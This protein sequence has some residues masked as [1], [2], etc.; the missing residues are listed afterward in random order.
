M[1]QIPT[2]YRELYKRNT[3]DA[4]QYLTEHCS[5]CNGTGYIETQENMFRDCE[6]VNEFYRIKK[7]IESGIDVKS[8]LLK[9][10]YIIEHFNEK[11]LN[12]L[13]TIVKEKPYVNIV[14]FPE[15]NKSW[16]SDI[17][18]KYVLRQYSDT[19]CA[20]VSAKQLIDFFFDFENSKYDN[21][22]EFL[23]NVKNLL[24]EGVGLE[25]NSKMKDNSSYVI[26]SLNGFLNERLE[27]SFNMRTYISLNCTKEV[28]HK[29]YSKE[30]ISLIINKFSGFSISS[31]ER[32]DN[33]YTITVKKFDNVFEDLDIIKPVRKK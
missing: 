25:Y 18:A 8:S 24:I 4:L 29:S 12:A 3:H 26:N 10:D 33:D 16:G 22:I 5:I 27:H 9:K 11:T 21:C 2:Y 13:N 6:C 14:F 17:I 19:S 23:K 7:Y 15:S 31:K 28:L 20:V 1:I 32:E 30:F